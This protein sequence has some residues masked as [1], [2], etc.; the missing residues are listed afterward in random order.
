MLELTPDKWKLIR[1]INKTWNDKIQYE[2]DSNHYHKA[3][4]WAFPF[5]GTGDC[6]D[7]AIAK[8]Q[9]LLSHGI[10]SRFATCWCETGGY[11][12]VLVVQTDHGYF[13]LDNRHDDVKGFSELP[14]KWDKI[15]RENGKWYVIV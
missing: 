8:R 1:K 10:D 5:D 6:E 12:A 9:A 15:E 14:Y 7:F 4:H 2:S 3:E 11:H 13:I